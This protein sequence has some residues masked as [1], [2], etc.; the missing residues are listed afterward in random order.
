MSFV[1]WCNLH[2]AR[3]NTQQCCTRTREERQI[4]F[5]IGC[6]LIPHSWKRTCLWCSG[7]ALRM[8]YTHTWTKLCTR[9]H[10]V[11]LDRDGNISSVSANPVSPDTSVYSLSSVRYRQRSSH[12]LS[13]FPCEQSRACSRPSSPSASFLSVCP[14][15]PLSP[16]GDVPLQWPEA[17]YWPCRLLW[18]SEGKTACLFKPPC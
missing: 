4:I 14:C 3:K 7:L 5:E 11:T 17:T 15:W 12:R 1:S 10:T 2:R 13:F 16:F 9:A 8:H 18:M 6:W